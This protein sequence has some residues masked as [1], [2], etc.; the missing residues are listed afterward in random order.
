LKRESGIHFY[1]STQGETDCISIKESA[2]AGCIPVVSSLE[3]FAERPY[4]I[5]IQGDPKEYHTHRN[6]AATIINL[7]T[8]R[9]AFEEAYNHVQR[10]IPKVKNW[11]SV[12]QSWL[13]IHQ[14]PLLNNDPA[15]GS[16]VDEMNA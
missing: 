9:Q 16:I 8:N 5:R 2:L 11:K 10:E 7:L 13:E 15:Q 1:L 6:A 14:L 3:V 4:T 12:A